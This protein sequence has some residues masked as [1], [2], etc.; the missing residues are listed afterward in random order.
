LTSP[1]FTVTANVTKD[2]QTCQPWGL[3]VKGGVPPYTISLA[4]P[5]SPSVT[6]V[7]LPYGD[8]TFTYINR[9]SP[10][11]QLIGGFT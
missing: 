10:D 4:S 6:N 2:L 5:N 3:T 7:T 9:A 11:G 1:S 8:D